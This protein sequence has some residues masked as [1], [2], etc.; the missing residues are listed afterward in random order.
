MFRSCLTNSAHALAPPRFS[1]LRSCQIALLHGICQSLQQPLSSSKIPFLFHGPGR[2]ACPACPAC[3]VPSQNV[4]LFRA[5][6]YCRRDITVA[7]LRRYGAVDW[8]NGPGLMLYTSQVCPFPSPSPLH[9]CASDVHLILFS[10]ACP[11]V[12]STFPA[13]PP[14]SGSP[15]KV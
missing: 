11:R 6:R 8:D 10:P 3:P 13:R 15:A 5:I 14:T 7:I 2:A 4:P 1:V 9:I 12:R